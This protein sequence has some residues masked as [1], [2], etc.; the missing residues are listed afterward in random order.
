MYASVCYFYQMEVVNA[1]KS[2]TLLKPTSDLLK[3]KTPVLSDPL[4]GEQLKPLNK[5]PR[6]CEHDC[7]NLF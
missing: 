4:V 2:K 3:T 6:L 7:S 1:E 5:L